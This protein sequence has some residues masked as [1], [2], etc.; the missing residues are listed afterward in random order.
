MTDEEFDAV[1]AAAKLEKIRALTVASVNR[2]R[3]LP[4]SDYN[5]RR[6]ALAQ[7]VID[8]LKQH[9][10]FVERRAR[11]LEEKKAIK[12][13]GD[14]R[15]KEKHAD[16]VRES[17]KKA[18][19]LRKSNGKEAE[20]RASPERRD[21]SRAYK[22]NLRRECGAIPRAEITKK[23]AEMDA[24]AAAR[25]TSKAE[26][27]ASFIGPPIPSI[28]MTEAEYYAWKVKTRPE[29]Y[30]KELDRAQR[31]KA[32][33]RPGYKDSLVKWAEMPMA[34]KEVK[35]LQY[36]ISREL[37]GAKNENHKRTA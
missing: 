30:A 6:V 3:G 29:F 14:A 15:Y 26:F 5:V 10:V 7:K 35:H 23:K 12:R 27:I 32:R 31:Y 28:A 11:R 19:E 4:V 37:K 18:R 16:K 17:A 8:D 21:A 34:V 13:A 9:P 24:A 33:T 25:R 36:L 22:E 1:M 2:A 20:Y